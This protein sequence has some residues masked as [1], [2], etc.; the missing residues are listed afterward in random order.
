MPDERDNRAKRIE[1]EDSGDILEIELDDLEDLEAL[2]EKAYAPAGDAGCVLDIDIED[3]DEYGAVTVGTQPAANGGKYA[4]V[5]A[6]VLEDARRT[7]E[8]ATYALCSHTGH[9]FMVY[10]VEVS[11]GVFEI[12]RLVTEV[13]ERG[14]SATV[15]TM[16]AHGT[17]GLSQFSGCP[18]C[19]SKRMSVCGGCGVMVCEGAVQKS[20]LSGPTLRCPSCGQRG[21]VE[22]DA[23]TVWGTAGG[24]G[25]GKGKGKMG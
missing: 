22:S 4:A 6:K 23:G 8:L 7:D 15:Q 5:D 16:P 20:F 21:A 12:S 11:P 9:P 13:P 14:D 24:K 2:P 3:L 19:G 1:D 18:H 10:W 17:F 25:K